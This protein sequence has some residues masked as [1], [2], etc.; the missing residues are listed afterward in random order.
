[1]SEEMKYHFHVAYGWECSK[2]GQNGLGAF[3]LNSNVDKISK[4][5]ISASIDWLKENAA[6]GDNFVIQNVIRLEE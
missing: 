6:K 2:T 4:E 1:M 3:Q 5:L